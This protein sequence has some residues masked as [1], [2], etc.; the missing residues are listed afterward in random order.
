MITRENLSTVKAEIMH[1]IPDNSEDFQYSMDLN[2]TS[3]M[4][5]SDKFHRV[6]EIPRLADSQLSVR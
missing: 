3:Y 4:N 5:S 1:L 2:S 6:H